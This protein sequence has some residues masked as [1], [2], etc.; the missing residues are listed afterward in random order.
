MKS[1]HRA[2]SS[3]SLLL[4]LAIPA[5]AQSS[6]GSLTGTVT[7]PN[8]QAV[9]DARVVAKHVSTGRE[10]EAVTSS[11]GLY[12]FPSLEV[13]SYTLA[14]TANGFKQLTHTG[15]VIAIATKA[16]VDLTLEVGEVSQS[17]TVTAEA[18]LLATA[19]SDIGTNF[20]PTLYKNAPIFVG[21]LRNPESFISYMPGVNNG[22]GDS[23]INGGNRRSKEILIDG[24]GNT[25]P[26]SG[27]V[28]FQFPTVEQFG[29][30]KLLNNNFA[31][32][33]GR[34]GGGIEIF[35]T[36]SG[37]SQ[38]H[39]TLFNFHRN[40]ALDSNAWANK[41][42]G[43]AK[44]K[45]RLNEFGLG[46]G[47]PIYL[48]KKIFGPLGGYNEDKDR[49]FFFFT[50]NGYRQNKGA[51]PVNLTLPT[52]KQRQGDFSELRNAQGQLIQIFDPQTG[53][54]F[55]NNVIPQ[56]RF[57]AVSR[58]ILPLL[59]QPTNANLVNNYLGVI[60]TDNVQDSWSL[61]INHNITRKQIISGWYNSL[62]QEALTDGPLPQP[63][64][65]RNQIAISANRPKFYRF[66]YDY[67]I[68]PTFNFH[69]TY[70]ITQ[71]R[72]Y[73]DSPSVGVGWPQRLGLKGV[74]E[75][76]TSAFPVVVFTDGRYESY[77]NTNGPKTKGT[78]FNF[79][80]HVRAD[81]SWLKGK[82]QFKFGFDKRW[83]RTTGERLPTGGADDAG[84]QGEFR[85]SP[86]QTAS[87]TAQNTTG[88]SFASFLLGAPSYAS[89]VFNASFTS[90]N[91]GYNAFYAQ[92]DWKATQRLT[93]NLGLRY[94]IP[95]P[96]WTDPDL[97]TSFD[98]NL[99]NPAV[100]L[101]GALAYAG[102]GP[103]R[104]GRRSFANTDY[105]SW[106][107][108]LGFAYSVN[109]KTVVRG[110]YGIYY[111]AGNG[112]TGGFC[113]GCAFGF[114]AKPEF[115]SP[116]NIAPAILWDNGFPTTGFQLPPFVSPSFANGQSPWYISPDSGKAPRIH[117]YNINI[118]RELPGK[119]VVELAYTGSRGQRLSWPRDPLNALD[120][121]YLALGDLLG[122]SITDPAV[123][124]A[125]FKKPYASFTGTLAQSLRPFPHFRDIP[126][127]YNPKGRSWYD[128]MM[129][130]VERRYADFSIMSSYVWSKSLTD[131]SGTQT[132]SNGTSLNPRSQN[133]YDDAH[134]KTLLYTDWPHVFNAVWSWDLPFGN[135]KR[136]LGSSNPVLN[137]LVGG[138]TLAGAHQ[139]RS[140]AL[141]LI[142]APNPLLSIAFYERKRA[143]LTGQEIRTGISY[144]D[145]D[146]N[147]PNSR[148][149]NRSAF[150]I[151]GTYE[152]GTAANY[153][154]DLRQPPVW[155][156]NISI[157]KRTAITETSNFEFRAEM[158]NPFNRTRFG[159]IIVDLNNPNFGRPT[160]PQVGARVIQVVGK[161]N[162]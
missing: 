28:A 44:N 18:P 1:I 129:L 39:G 65:G 99:D 127:E 3:V 31:A 25:N 70:G 84:V 102:E 69:A 24:A 23:S 71:F 156:E 120:P 94:E 64:F 56:S 96:R 134:E 47:G 54:P 38:Y 93:L 104:T 35:T 115:F 145:L 111:G 57:S 112:L 17:V 85:F 58:A 46:F 90:A 45:Y 139:Y 92:T 126:N 121:K 133:P 117:N 8:G 61:K 42:A 82:H 125:G 40:S 157:I 7:D 37:G 53:Q 110:G 80:D 158:A 72:Q 10:L 59:P 36:A 55:P 149:I 29:E 148:W 26:E 51:T 155:S 43:R 116:D 62:Q 136:L 114:T 159:G 132:S 95:I 9:A 20:Q 138:W 4:L 141:I 73:F 97:F 6:T 108:R 109:D 103:G 123:V 77:G 41:A 143:N 33:Y 146:P 52:L 22:S 86:F 88:D 5:F 152:F 15:T 14:V 11:A 13:G 66:N 150:A 81:L 128:S 48:P 76:V 101:K 119:L 154:S 27:G 122:R 49:T 106:G 98:P 68:S 60:V 79:T 105:S 160:G 2:V 91:F 32:E 135:G 21:G 144:K 12:T 153:L 118:Q 63:L 89:R 147:N 34:T 50:Y 107:P 162:F 130:K 30:F 151:P 113:L 74:A 100:G 78:Q 75:G 124:A 137:R 140:G 161:I 131:A 67:L 87:R 83:M 16:V 142:N 19:T